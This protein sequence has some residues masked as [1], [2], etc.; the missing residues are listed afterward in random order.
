M[1]KGLEKFFFPKKTDMWPIFEKM[2]NVTNHQG[3][4]NQNQNECHLKP[5]RMYVIQNTRE[6]KFW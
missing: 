1:G 5:A 6:Y 4:E 2:S 3:K